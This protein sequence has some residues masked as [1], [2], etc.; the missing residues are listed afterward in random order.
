MSLLQN[1]KNKNVFTAMAKGT[2]YF[3]R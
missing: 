3:T 2:M 1:N